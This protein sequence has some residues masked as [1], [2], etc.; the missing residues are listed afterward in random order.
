MK[1]P[2]AKYKCLHLFSSEFTKT[3]LELPLHVPQ[4]DE[5]EEAE[6]EVYCSTAHARSPS[7]SELIHIKHRRT[8]LKKGPIELRNEQNNSMYKAMATS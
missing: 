2:F 8:Q 4:W 6:K 5:P 7:G 1:V 3:N